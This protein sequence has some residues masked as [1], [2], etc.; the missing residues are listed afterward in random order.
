MLS[1]LSVTL[2][3]VFVELFLLFAV[4]TI[5]FAMVRTISLTQKR[6]YSQMEKTAVT[7]SE[8]IM[9]MS[10]ESAVSI[11]KNIY[12]N[13][14]I[15]EFLN[16][17]YSSS[18]DYYSV[19]YPI[20][21][22]SA[23]NIADTNIVNT[24]IIYTENPTVLPGG[25]IKKL[26]DA[27]E[28][29]W[30]REFVKMKK[31]TILCIDP[32]TKKL[33]LV[34]KLDYQELKTGDSYLCLY[35]NQNVLTK[36]ADDLGFDG[37]LY[38]MSGGDLLYSSDKKVKAADDININQ[39]FECIKRNYYTV[40]I[41][42]YSCASKDTLWDFIKLN[43]SVLITL[44]VIVTA[45]LIDG[46]LMALNIRRRIKPALAEYETNGSVKS[47]AGSKNGSDDIGKLLDICGEMSEKLELTGSE[48]KLHNDSLM[49]K[50]DEYNSLFA[51]AMRLDAEIAVREKLPEIRSAGTHDMFP[52]E[53]ELEL[54]KKIANR[55]EAE[56]SGM[57]PEGK[58]SV[59]AYSLVLIAWDVFGNLGGESVK[60]A[61]S[62]DAAV[63]TFEGSKSPKATDALKLNAIFEDDSVSDEY[64]FD[65]SYRFN[66]YLRLKHCFGKNVSMELNT[67][68]KLKLVF[69][70]YPET[71]KGEH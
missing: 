33:I 34:R 29:C 13:E 49:R 45:A 47:L 69:K 25:N 21:Q 23:M 2:K 6:K 40:D 62:G 57:I 61:A 59:P 8:H 48:F 70:I 41:E 44:I 18:S 11:A 22:N 51:T 35:L 39:D 36:F 28:D 56:F 38:V 63:I 71:E 4:L 46:L 3:F 7:A 37:E 53:T 66:P 52:L 10:I 26:E 43:K 68:N 30:Y 58:W 12:T 27:K 65:T 9:N 19:Y 31:P 20:Q 32:A 24:C 54:L 67:K 55:F 64:S 42:F 14:A 17:E 15:Y 1:N 50:S 60:T 5:T 16:R